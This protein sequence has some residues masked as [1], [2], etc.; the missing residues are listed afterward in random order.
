MPDTVQ[1][2]HLTLGPVQGFVA[3]A[4]RTR[5]FWAG[6]FL[7]S[8]LASVA[9]LSVRKQGGEIDFPIPDENFLDA[10]Q[11]I[12]TQCL[13]RQGSVPNRFKAFG[14]RVQEDFDP[15]QVERAI[16]Q[17]WLALCQTVWD[18]DL[19]PILS[20]TGFAPEQLLTT[21][22]IWQRQ[23]S[24]YWEINWCL[25]DDAA[26]SNLLDRR[27]NWR[28]HVLPDEPGHKCMMMEG[29]QEL[30]GLLETHKQPLQA[31]WDHVRVGIKNG[32]MD[33]REKEYLSALGFIKR[34]FVRHFKHFKVLLD[35]GVGLQGWELRT[36]VPSLFYMAAAPRYVELLQ[37]AHEKPKVLDALNAF[38]DAA[39]HLGRFSEIDTPLA[40]VKKQV[41][42]CDLPRHYAGID[43]AMFHLTELQRL[44][45]QSAHQAAANEVL[46]RLRNVLKQA[47]LSEP[48]PFYAILI[49][50]GDSLGSQMSDATKQTRISQGLNAF[51]NKVPE[52]VE[53]HDGFLVYAGGDDVLALVTVNKAVALALA[54]RECYC[55]CFE[56]QNRQDSSN[57]VI[58]S[59]SGALV[60]AHS[61]NPLTLV[62]AEAHRLL[63]DIAK[64]RTGRDAL[65]IEV[66][67]PGG[68]YALWSQPWAHLLAHRGNA[69][70]LLT[71]VVELFRKRESNSAFTNRFIFKISEVLQRLPED[72]LRYNVDPS[73]GSQTNVLRAL[74]KV[75]LVHSGLKLT[76]DA[77]RD[78]EI[79]ALIE[80]LLQL[81]IP[82]R[83]IT[84][85]TGQT[86][87]IESSHVFDGDGLKLVRFLA[88]GGLV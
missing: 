32:T 33:L 40:S 56:K 29:F 16:Q 66:L 61:K 62:L 38:L 75:E 46:Q 55:A 18:Q 58:T 10:M 49:M 53:T 85:A 7:L 15:H 19:A 86:L 82:H 5:D 52:L 72:L 39:K 48:S 50:D 34:R 25:T 8:W 43:G 20:D 78:T 41:M 26:L 71:E 9:M 24:T 4:R 6:S 63:D 69:T 84:D 3:Q 28:T 74:L 80:P 21:Q 77:A 17:A 57:P 65:A 81:A 67:K 35:N 54:L 14:A 64:E 70:D 73:R 27:K 87:K 37:Q 88:K 13:P 60:F 12:S 59:L 30:S 2:F 23:L 76:T 42:Q 79:Q 83:R 44:G 68:L 1:Y 47:E 45:T 51:T 36:Q 31:F 22:A 11:G